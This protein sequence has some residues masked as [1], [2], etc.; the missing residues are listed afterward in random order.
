ME[1][2]SHT[3]LQLQDS[4]VHTRANK[5]LKRVPTHEELMEAN[6]DL[7][8]MVAHLR[9]YLEKEGYTPP[10]VQG[11]RA[12]LSYMLLLLLHAAP[13][14]ILP[15]GIRVVATLLECEEAAYTANI[16]A[17]AI[18][19]KIDPVLDSMEKVADQAQGMASDTRMAV[20]WLYRTG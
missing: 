10:D 9:E 19:C 2:G 14:S 16:I 4:Q 13:T 11:G 7:L 6:K 12:K 5:G 8:T 3:T 17:T 18:L 15:K 20:D 1:L